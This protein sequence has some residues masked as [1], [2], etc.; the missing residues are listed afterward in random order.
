MPTKPW[1]R[2]KQLGYVRALGRVAGYDT[3]G[4]TTKATLFVG[5]T[6]GLNLSGLREGQK[7]S[8]DAVERAI[9]K[10]RVGQVG[11]GVYGATI[12]ATEGRY[13]GQKERSVKVELVFVPFARE[14]TPAAFARNVK[15][16]AQDVATDLAQREIVIEW[17][18][19]GKLGGRTDTATPKAAPPATRGEAFCAWVRKHS[20]AARRPSDPCYARAKPKRK[21]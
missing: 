3:Y 20:N 4:P 21:K 2:D 18:A 19:P 5:R 1:P 7:I 6:A 11:V 14:K 16:L 12:T 10:A 15:A 17:T 9:A 8:T 13:R